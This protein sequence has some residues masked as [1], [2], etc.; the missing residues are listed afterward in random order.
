MKKII[1]LS[2]VWNCG[3]ANGTEWV[4]KMITGESEYQEETWR[5]KADTIPEIDL[6]QAVRRFVYR[7][8]ENYSALYDYLTENGFTVEYKNCIIYSNYWEADTR[9]IS[10]YD[11]LIY[12]GKLIENKENE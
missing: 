5:R 6:W 8:R 2:N 7:N 11:Y 4:V 3:T 9:Y 10:I 12:A 1:E